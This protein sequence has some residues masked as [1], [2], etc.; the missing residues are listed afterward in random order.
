MT[1]ARLA[2]YET[3]RRPE[4]AHSE[5]LPIARQIAEALEAAHEQGIVH[6]DLKPGNIKVRA[7]GTVKVLD[8]GLAKAMDPAGTSNPNVSHSP[9]LTHQGTSAGMIIGTAAYMSPEQ[10]KGKTVDKRADIWAFGVVLYEMLTGKR[11]FK[12]EDVSETLAS[13]LKDTLSMDALPESTPPRLKW[14]IERCLERDLKNRLR[15]IGEARIEIARIEAGAPDG[16]AALAP[17]TATGRPSALPWATAAAFAIALIAT[18]LAWPPWRAPRALP[19]TRLDVVTPPTEDP[20]SFAV[21]PD[22]SQIAFEGT[23]EG[24]ARLWLRSL[25]I[26]T[27]QPIPGTEGGRSPFWS[28]DGRSLGFFAHGSLKRIDIGGGAPQTL[29]AS[30]GRGGAWGP[31]DLI[32]FT[33]DSTSALLQVS[34]SGG[35][36]SA[37]T[38]LAP[39]QSSHRW[40]RFLPDGKRFLYYV[41]GALD[42]TG[43]Y[44]GTLDGTSSTRL[45]AADSQ[46]VYLPPG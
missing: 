8:F 15:D 22:G 36:T 39:H 23:D 29:A 44:M 17:S 7:D 30:N 14:L 31:G 42:E 3:T 20:A 38:T 19:V 5:A 25:S 45:T 24:G 10:A 13:V 40:P 43:I 1:G 21:S 27:P 34:A 37:L 33:P 46:G 32:I 2:R 18:L 35:Q 6:R 11:A 12:G 28:P 9:T 26:T 4:S 16:R 41:R